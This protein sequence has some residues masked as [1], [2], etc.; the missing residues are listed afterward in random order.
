MLL[1]AVSRLDSGH[2]SLV[3]PVCDTRALALD[4]SVARVSS[5][6]N[7][8]RHDPVIQLVIFV[9]TGCVVAPALC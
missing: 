7:Q 4:K 8:Q 5:F 9:I 3:M 2:K 6:V 1:L